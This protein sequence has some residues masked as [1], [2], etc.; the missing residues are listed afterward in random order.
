MI[1]FILVSNCFWG[2]EMI[3]VRFCIPL[4]YCLLLSIAYSLITKRR[5]I[6]SIAPA[7]L[8][9][10]IIML[11][12][13]LMFSSINLGI[14]IGI[15]VA[16]VC[17]CY[18]VIK[19]IKN[20]KSEGRCYSSF[21]RELG[22]IA[23]LYTFVFVTNYGKFFY[24]P[25]EF[26]FWGD[27]IKETLRLDAL[28]CTSSKWVIHG[29]YVPAV[30]LFETLWCRLSFRYGE[31]DAY[32][33]I[34]MLELSMMIPMVVNTYESFMQK[35][36]DIVLK[37]M[38]CVCMPLLFT[39][40]KFYHTIYQD[41][42][43]GVLI[44]YCIYL[45]FINTE[46]GELAST[47]EILISLIVLVMSKMTAIAFLPLIIVFY[48]A[49]NSLFTNRNRFQIGLRCFAFMAVPMA[50]W[51]FYNNF[52]GQ[53]ID[54]KNNAQAYGGLSISQLLYLLIHR[55]AISYQSQVERSYLSALFFKGIVGKMPYAWFIM[56]IFGGVWLYSLKFDEKKTKRIIR[57]V[58]LW[59]LLAGIAYA[60]M[61]WLLYLTAFSE[62]EALELASFTRYMSSYAF[63]A[64]LIAVSTMFYFALDK[65]RNYILVGSIILL[66][67]V[68]LFTGVKQ[69]EPG[70][71]SGDRLQFEGEVNYIMNTV[72][73]DESVL[74][75]MR[76]TDGARTMKAIGRM[77]YYCWPMDLNGISPGKQLFDGDMWSEDISANEFIQLVSGYRN[78]YFFGLDDYFIEKYSS[79]FW[80]PSMVVEGKIYSI[81]V[82]DGKI[83]TRER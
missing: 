42:I 36:K 23:L 74:L 12:A 19:S 25:D 26:I 4:L 76:G 16:I 62:Y 67:N 59:I 83:A 28:Y 55:N 9:H 58:D 20:N 18:A 52:V 49:S 73:E 38:I 46:C 1:V 65:F 81:D 41:M 45:I 6:N 34:Q 72:P 30:T 39:E 11:A 44:F 14:I 54:T 5:L 68:F 33:A 50:I 22:V 51:A 13:G 17:C 3:A 24:S 48:F 43:M 77:R 78:I 32:R 37:C 82:V 57:L 69:L 70:I 15:I 35:K 53:F 7:F 29:D 66:E 63:A 21:L 31:A 64:L 10:I 56:L 8:L 2:K 47:F 80:N 27:F 61:M 79:T 60:A 40:V 71:I 75:V